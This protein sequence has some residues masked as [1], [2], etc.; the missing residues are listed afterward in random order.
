M[1]FKALRVAAL[2]EDVAANLETFLG[3]LPGVRDFTVTP[4]TQEISIVFDE[5]QLDF[6]SLVEVMTKAGCPLQNI[7]AALLL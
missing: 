7:D 1:E 4:E 3:E 5:D 2:T 6:R